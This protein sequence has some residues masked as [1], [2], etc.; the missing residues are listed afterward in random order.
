MR[1][2]CLFLTIFICCQFG[3]IFSISHA[4]TH[5]LSQINIG[6]HIVL[7]GEQ[8]IKL[9]N[10]GLLMMSATLTCPHGKRIAGKWAKCFD[11]PAD[12][13]YDSTNVTCTCTDSSLVYDINTSSC[14][15]AGLPADADTLNCTSP[16]GYMDTWNG[17]SS[18]AEHETVCLADPR[19][20][21]TYKVR[22]LADGQCWMVDS[23]KFGGNYG[24]T[25]GCSV[26]SGEGNFTYAW[27]GGSGVAGCT[28]GGSNSATKAQETFATGY[29][30]HCRY[31]GTVNNILYNNYLYDWVAAMQSTLAYVGSSASFSGAQQGLCPSSWHLPTSGNTDSEFNS[32]VSA[33]NGSM[34]SL[35]SVD[36]VNFTYSGYASSF[37]NGSLTGQN[38]WGGLWSSN[39]S[40]NNSAYELDLEGRSDINPNFAL[41]KSSGVAIRCIKD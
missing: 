26:N 14:T 1:K 15:I 20:Y 10:N 23:L 36:M 22:K 5:P 27:C 25:D 2:C 6:D 13:T 30:G 21:R 35:R 11:C 28:A 17:C 37:D 16:I 40:N 31:V 41:Y 8:F 12:A 3:A 19:D 4:T 34:D 33:Y 29:Y 7:G 38:N 39:I 24:D 32:L 18:L 9:N